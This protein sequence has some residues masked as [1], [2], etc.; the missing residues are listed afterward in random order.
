M[1]VIFLVVLMFTVVSA[2]LMLWRHYL[3]S[4]LALMALVCIVVANFLFVYMFFNLRKL[5]AALI[6]LQHTKYVQALQTTMPSFIYT[7]KPTT[8]SVNYFELNISLSWEHANF[9]FLILNTFLLMVL[10]L[11]LVKF[12][13]APMLMLEV[14]SI[15]QCIFIPIMKLPTCPSL[16]TMNIPESV[17]NIRVCGSKLFPK[18][19]LNWTD[20]SMLGPNENIYSVPT[21][22]KINVWQ[23]YKLR[24]ILKKPFFINLHTDHA[25]YLSPLTLPHS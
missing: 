8:A 4:V 14:T 3:S 24:K 11:R 6:I 9:I 20:F 13:H 1:S 22:V 2:G 12:R 16:V 10:V 5:S 19:H 23:S 25:G 17:T 15:D 21:R 7:R 18:I